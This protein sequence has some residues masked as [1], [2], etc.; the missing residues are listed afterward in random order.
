VR[1]A[2]QGLGPIDDLTDIF[3]KGLAF[4]DIAGGKNAFAMDAGDTGLNAAKGT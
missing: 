3:D 4:G 2:L 1:V